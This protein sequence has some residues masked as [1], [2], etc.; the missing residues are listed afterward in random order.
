LSIEL[1]LKLVVKKPNI[2]SKSTSKRNPIPGC[3]DEGE[4]KKIKKVKR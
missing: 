1:T 2:V 3:D 4:K